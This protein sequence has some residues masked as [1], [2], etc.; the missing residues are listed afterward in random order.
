MDGVAEV[1]LELGEDGF[2]SVG[3]MLGIHNRSSPP[4]HSSATSGLPEHAHIPTR[5]PAAADDLGM[6]LL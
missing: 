5:W 1:G 3:L 6:R 2:K 4:A